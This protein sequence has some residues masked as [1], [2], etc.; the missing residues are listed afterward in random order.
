LPSQRRQILLHFRDSA[1]MKILAAHPSRD[2][3]AVK[4][5]LQEL[6]PTPPLEVGKDKKD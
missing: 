3:D 4:R 2:L 6:F 5:Y 1:E